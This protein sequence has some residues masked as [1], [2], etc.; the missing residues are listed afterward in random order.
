M[1]VS[2]S[3][4]SCVA[5]VLADRGR[6]DPDDPVSAYVPEVAAGGYAGATVRHLL[7]MRSG[8]RF[9]ED[10]LDPTSD[11]KVF[12]QVTGW[13]P[14]TG[15]VP[16]STYDYLAALPAAREHGGR[17]E[18]RSCETDMLGWVCERAGGVRM[19]DLLSEVLWAPL[20]TE[21]DLDASVDRAGAVLHDGG[22]A[23]TLRDL[24]RFGRMVA[25]HGRVGD[26]QVVP[27]RW[28]DDAATGGPDSREAFAASGDTRMPGGMYRSQFWVP[29]PDRDVLMCLGIHGQMVYVD[30][31]RRLVAVKLSS[32]PL[33]VDPDIYDDTIALID[34]LAALT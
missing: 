14:N 25:D 4:T 12:D 3:L 7:D 2:K 20:G 33:P 5:A 1:S 21:Q 26:R 22:F 11:V 30:R 8:I 24:A 28:L 13:A 16:T 31:S 29:Y 18:Y 6:L 34:Q 19:P 17:F 15:Q 32:A 23:C 27:A 9:N 10:Y